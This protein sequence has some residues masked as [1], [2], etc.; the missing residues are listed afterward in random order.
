[1][2]D[3]EF[4]EKVI[5]F[6]AEIRELIKHIPQSETCIRHS[7]AIDKANND[8][9]KADTASKHRDRWLW[10]GFGVLCIVTAGIK[11]G[12]AILKIIGVI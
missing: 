5:E 10:A 1:M 7:K 8:I 4:K 2:T 11:Y 6:M 9:E 12:P 3:Q